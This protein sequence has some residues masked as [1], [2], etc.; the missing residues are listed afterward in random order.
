MSRAP[1][2]LRD[3]E[4]LAKEKMSSVAFHYYAGGAGDEETL[5]ENQAAFARYTLQPRV[6]VDVSNLSTQTTLLGCEVSAPIGLAPTAVH[7]LAHPEAEVATARAAA[8]ANVVYCA[9]TMSSCSLEEI[10]V[11]GGTRWFQL[12]T[13]SERQITQDLIKRAEATDYK[14]LVLTV[15]LPVFGRRERDEIHNFTLPRATMGNFSKYS[16]DPERMKQILSG[17]H[18]PRLSWKDVEWL[19]AQSK[20]P[21]VLKGILCAEDAMRAVQHGASALVVSNHGGRQLDRSVATIE[22]L[23][24]IV[25]A[26]DGK[27]EVY[28]DGGVRRG[29]DVA[30]ALALGAKAAFIGRPYLYALAYDGEEGVYTV[31]QMLHQE[32]ENAM[33]LLGTPTLTALSPQYLRRHK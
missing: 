23:R 29:I 16:D 19:K 7:R 10:A 3:F 9:S 8:R 33:S 18:D 31:I 1:V 13:H 28:L 4:A 6:L 27:I 2:N 24:E 20:L 11:A 25:E 17:M 5:R 14:A 30:T 32:L 26:V 12:Y 15:D 21:L 22:V